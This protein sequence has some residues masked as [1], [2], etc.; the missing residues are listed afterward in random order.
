MASASDTTSTERTLYSPLKDSDEIRLLYLQPRSAGAKIQCLLKRVKVSDHLSYEAL[1]YMWGPKS[2]TPVEING[3]TYEVRDNLASAL[4][5]LRLETEQRIL[6]ADALCINQDNIRERNHQVIQM[7]SIYENASRVVIWLGPSEGAVAREPWVFSGGVQGRLDSRG[8]QTINAFFRSEYWTRLWIIQEVLLARQ[9]VIQCGFDILLPSSWSGP[10][11]L[12][13]VQRLYTLHQSECLIPIR[14]LNNH[15]NG[16]AKNPAPLLWLFCQYS[17]AVC[18]EILDKVFGLH[19]LTS[20]CCKENVKVDYEISWEALCSKILEHH[21]ACH[22]RRRYESCVSMSQEFHIKAKLDRGR[23]QN[24]GQLSRLAEPNNPWRPGLCTIH[25]DGLC[26]SRIN[27]T[28]CPLKD[29]RQTDLQDLPQLSSYMLD[30]LSFAHSTI[31][32]VDITSHADLIWSAGNTP[33]QVGPVNV[34]RVNRYGSI[35][36]PDAKWAVRLWK[37]FDKAREAVLGTPNEDCRL[38]F[39]ENGLVCFVPADTEVGDAI[40]YFFNS[41]VLAIIRPRGGNRQPNTSLIGRAVDVRNYSTQS[42]PW[43]SRIPPHWPQLGPENPV[44]FNFDF[45]T[46]YM[47]TRASVAHL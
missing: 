37:L 7:G 14:L 33:C 15:I 12:I 17:H 9:L 28:T 36:G 24:R 47:M 38:A 20:R 8:V 46:L 18:E 4:S 19:A 23:F 42:T 21:I 31:T 5:H 13:D 40:C 25:L 11:P 2:L 26:A 43:I 44:Q 32:L 35:K 45:S 16:L 1:S 27:V 22:L 29:Y 30:Y 3:E 41:D 6:W 10:D 34:P 39:A